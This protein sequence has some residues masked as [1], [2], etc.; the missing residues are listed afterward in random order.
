MDDCETVPEKTV[1]LICVDIQKEVLT[2]DARV[3]TFTRTELH[4]L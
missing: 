4:S 2:P 1:A 3:K